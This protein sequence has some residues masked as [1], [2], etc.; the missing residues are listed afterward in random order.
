MRQFEVRINNKIGALASVCDV[1]AGT[2]I[3]IKAI[4]SELRGDLGVL[5]FITDDEVGT[6]DVLKAANLNF[7]EYEIVPVRLRDE[8]GE[9]AKLARGLAKLNI[10][11][12]SIFLLNKENGVS[13]IAFKVNDLKGA[14]RVLG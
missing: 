2:G 4:S 9:L 14:K 13:E 10:D 8:P 5:K 12:E 3:N 11:I 7:S 6:R 1:L